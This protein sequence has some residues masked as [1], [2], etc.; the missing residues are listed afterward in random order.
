MNRTEAQYEEMLETYIPKVAVI[1][2]SR[3]FVSSAGAR[4]NVLP[5]EQEFE[6]RHF[7]RVDLIVDC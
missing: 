6:V 4:E 2:E 1:G 5:S 7:A 3:A